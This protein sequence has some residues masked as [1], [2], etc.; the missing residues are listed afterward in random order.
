MFLWLLL[1]DRLNTRNM[2]HRRHYKIDNDDYSRLLCHNPSEECLA[3]LFFKCPFSVQC[4]NALGIVWPD[5]GCSLHMAHVAPMFMDVFVVAAW[6][7]WKEQNQKLFQGVPPSRNSWLSRFKKVAMLANRAKQ[8][9]EFILSFVATLMLVSALP[10]LPV[11]TSLS[12]YLPQITRLLTHTL[13]L[14]N[15]HL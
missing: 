14:C 9:L 6:G 8:R 2:L 4:W 11:C 5:S 15:S 7:I 3:H 1:P 13:F 10:A 12:L